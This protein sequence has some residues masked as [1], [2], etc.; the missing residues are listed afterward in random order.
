[1]LALHMLPPSQMGAAH[2]VVCACYPPHCVA[3]AVALANG[4]DTWG[5]TEGDTYSRTVVQIEEPPLL[6]RGERRLLCAF[7]FHHDGHVSTAM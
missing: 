6:I 7:I 1:M 2:G 5:G 3:H 4:C